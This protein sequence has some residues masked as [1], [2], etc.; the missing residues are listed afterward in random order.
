MKKCAVCHTE[1]P[2]EAFAIQRS[3]KDGH[4]PYCKECTKVR[5]RAS[6]A[7]R[8]KHSWV[9][10]KICKWCQVLKSKTEFPRSED[11]KVGSRCSA[12]V[13]DIA[14]HESSGERRCNICREWQP[15]SAFYPSQ[16]RKEHVACVNCIKEQVAQPDYR[17]RRRDKQLRKEFGITLEQYFELINRQGGRCPVCLVPFEPGNSSYHLDHVHDGPFKGRIRAIVHGECNR[18]VLWMH[19]D[20]ATLRRAADLID[21]PLT[22]WVVPGVPPSE[23]RN[24]K[25][26]QK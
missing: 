15:T 20:S 24:R 26:R 2:F 16:L 25:N 10:D 17:R 1:K 18:T 23:I 22:D 13:A 9:N 14:L 19:E 8:G 3:S 6:Y 5:M 12:C 4:H 11:G 21:N 7:A